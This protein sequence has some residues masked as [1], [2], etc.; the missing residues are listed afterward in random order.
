MDKGRVGEESKGKEMDE[1]PL[2]VWSLLY[3]SCPTEVK[4]KALL[5]LLIFSRNFFD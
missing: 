5:Y 4:A 3:A 1:C 2:T